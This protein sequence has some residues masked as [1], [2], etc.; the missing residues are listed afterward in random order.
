M[1]EM[2][3]KVGNR[4]HNGGRQSGRVHLELGYCVG[5]V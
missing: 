3:V 4:L 2:Y 1:V 5:R